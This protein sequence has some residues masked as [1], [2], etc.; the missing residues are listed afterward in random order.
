MNL[1]RIQHKLLPINKQTNRHT[2]ARAHTH[3]Q[4]LSRAPSPTYAVSLCAILVLR[5]FKV[6]KHEII[7]FLIRASVFNLRKRAHTDTNVGEEYCWAETQRQGRSCCGPSDYIPLYIYIQLS[8]CILK[9]DIRKTVLESDLPER[10]Y[11][12]RRGVSVYKK[13]GN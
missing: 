6:A 4:T 12:V 13:N 9:S 11:C 1:L 2:R 10:N 5:N 8:I 3:T 7:T